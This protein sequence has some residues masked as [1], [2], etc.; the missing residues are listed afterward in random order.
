M[1]YLQ[2]ALSNVKRSLVRALFTTLAATIAFLLFALLSGLVLGLDET[3]ERLSDTRI[4]VLSRTGPMH[5]LPISYRNRIATIDHV[6]KVTHATIFGGYFQTPTNPVSAAGIDIVD[7]LD[8]VPEIR[9]P[10]EQLDRVLQSR[11]GAIVGSETAKRYGWNL[12]DRIPLKSAF[13]TNNRGDQSWD[14]EVLAIANTG[15][16]DD[17]VF[18]DGVFFD[19]RY[20]NESRTT[21]KNTVQHFVVAIDN[22]EHF[23]SVAREIDEL[24]KNSLAETRSFSEKQWVSSQLRQVED[25]RAFVQLVVGSVFFSLLFLVGTMMIQSTKRRITE[26]GVL[27]AI[28][29]GEWDIAMMI[30]SETSVFVIGGAIVAMVV[31]TFAFP[32]I[33]AFLA[34]VTMSLPKSVYWN[35]L[36][37]AIGS[38]VLTSLWPV[39]HLYRLSITDAIAGR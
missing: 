1:R 3:L 31:A 19:Y 36:I 24:F 12:G 26:F 35:A 8:V 27:K 33:Y 16:D 7:F 22:P 5:P 20:L 10:D 13:W 39:L 29:F 30:V 34:F 9:V 23:S 17:K 4:R 2:L 18:A 11:A 28:G 14:F 37:I 15:P 38:V 32:P 21:H 6:R 25:L